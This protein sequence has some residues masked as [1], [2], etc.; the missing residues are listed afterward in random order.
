MS[1]GHR[2][3]CCVTIVVCS[4]H[5]SFPVVRGYQAQIFSGLFLLNSPPAHRPADL[6]EKALSS[7]KALPGNALPK[8]RLSHG[9][10]STPGGG[11]N[12]N[13]VEL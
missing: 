8:T 7:R 1:P 13:G 2:H 6:F 11:G 5:P 12:L 10:S 4:R 9:R 3:P